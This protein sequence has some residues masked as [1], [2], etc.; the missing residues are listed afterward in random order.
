MVFREVIFL[1]KAVKIC[2]F[3]LFT[4]EILS[5][6]PV[7]L[8]GQESEAAPAAAVENTEKMLIPGG[9]AVGITLESD[10]V[11]V[12][13]TGNVTG[14]DRHIYTPAAQLLN[15]GDIILEADGVYVNDKEALE[16]AIRNSDE[17]LELTVVRDDSK[18]DVSITPV[19]CLEDG[20]NKIGVWVRDS[21]QGIG[22]L[23]YIDPEDSSFGALGHGVYDTDTGKL[24][25]L[26][27]GLVVESRITGIKKSEKGAPGE[28]TGVLDKGSV[29]G[30]IAENNE[31]GIY[32]NLNAETADSLYK[33]ALPAASADEVKTGEA[34]ILCTDEEGNIN[35]YEIEIE[36]VNL[37]HSEE[38]KGMVIRIT[39]DELKD[40]AGGIVQGMSGSPIIQNGKI[41]GAVTHV[42][43]KEP[44][45]GYGIFIENMLKNDI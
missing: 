6:F 32:G 27:S 36:S 20:S 45:R 8:N 28:L 13:G 38:D 42:F 24:M 29:M 44:D 7:S 10:G 11:L 34:V 15:E 43:I 4:A 19:E 16:T 3:S 17:T 1:K 22:T 30:D 33:E 37:N 12:L 9:Q 21:T 31:C 5:F 25:A 2:F 23:T 14:K 39:D 35:E 26:K 41:I 40:A 18:V